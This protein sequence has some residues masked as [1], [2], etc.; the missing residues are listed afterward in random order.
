MVTYLVHVSFQISFGRVWQKTQITVAE[1]TERYFSFDACTQPM[2]RQAS[3]IGWL[4]SHQGS[5]CLSH[6]STILSGRL[7]A[8]R[9]KSAVWLRSLCHT[10]TCR[11]TGRPEEGC[12]LLLKAFLRR[13]TLTST[14]IPLPHLA[15]REAG[16]CGPYSGE[17]KH[18]EFYY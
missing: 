17:L 13:T 18:R 5:R 1:K 10:S 6:L 3:L 14:Q 11:K 16:Q 4:H 15:A 2:V 9:S 12:A 7:C 8:S